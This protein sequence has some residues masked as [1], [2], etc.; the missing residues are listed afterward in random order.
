MDYSKP[1]DQELAIKAL[2]DA[3]QKG[4]DMMVF[5]G[6]GIS[7]SGVVNAAQ[8]G[9]YDLDN[10]EINGKKTVS[11]KGLRLSDGTVIQDDIGF[12]VSA[13]PTALSRMT[14]QAASEALRRS[15]ARLIDLAKSGWKIIADA[16][17]T[18]RWAEGLGYVFGRA[19]IRPGYFEFG[20]P[21]GRRVS[22]ADAS[23]LDPQTIIVGTR[24]RP[25]VDQR[26][27]SAAKESKPSDA[28][29][30]NDLWSVRPRQ[31][32]TRYIFDRG[33][34]QERARAWMSTL[35][36]KAIFAPKPGKETKDSR[37]N[38]TTFE[39]HGID[40][41]YTKSAPSEGF[42]GLHRGNFETAQVLI[43]A[44]PQGVDDWNSSRALTGTRG[45]YLNGLMRDLGIGE[46]YLVIKT[47]PVAMDGATAEEW[48]HVRKNT[49]AYREFAIKD[50]LS[51]KGV[52]GERNIKA[53][54]IDGEVAK[55]EMARILKKLKIDGID[56]VN[57][58]RDANDLSAGIPQAGED[59]K[60]LGIAA[61][62]TKIS[63]KMADIPRSHL[64][65]WSRIWEGTGGDTTINTL[66]KGRGKVF[67]M[68]TP[69]WVVRQ[70]VIPLSAT[71]ESIKKLRQFLTEQGVRIGKE[72]MKSFLER[73][74]A[75]DKARADAANSNDVDRLFAPDNLL[76]PQPNAQP[77]T[78]PALFGKA[79]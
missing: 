50:A 39:T 35:D 6:G 78:C 20:A 69:N 56:I 42:F 43:L 66:G 15:F 32:D 18:N 31:K 37:G 16:G 17:W 62:N 75:M 40:A 46:N 47:A 74:D 10:V 70:K 11:L 13:H 7:G 71:V 68:I 63:A 34:G 51:Q 8:L 38:D 4:I 52:N 54:F 30:P 57:I 58:Q 76:A 36:R 2:K 64:T 49:E 59:A 73:K 67:A 26:L 61:R 53:I 28:K 14:P 44:D 5:T 1:A 19:D 79:G 27:L 24:N 65:W 41:F 55:G 21:D 72:S 12:A 77:K 29:D 23:R 22:R 3:G 25:Q 48:E 9:G 33:P 60:R 45:Q